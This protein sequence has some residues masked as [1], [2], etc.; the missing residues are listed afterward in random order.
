MSCCN[1]VIASDGDNTYKIPH[2]NKEALK[3][4]DDLPLVLPILAAAE[5]RLDHLLQSINEISE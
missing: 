2:M 5:N 1:K 3:R 4:N